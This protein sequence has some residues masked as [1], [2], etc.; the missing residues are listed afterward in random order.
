MRTFSGLLALVRPFALKYD[1][2]CVDMQFIMCARA[3]PLYI[4]VAV[5]CALLPVQSESRSLRVA[6]MTHT[7]TP[8]PTT[9]TQ[10][11]VVTVTLLLPRRGRA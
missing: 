1:A 10:T 9:A 4:S 3:Q 8:T 7:M 2:P 5:Y 11:A 6:P